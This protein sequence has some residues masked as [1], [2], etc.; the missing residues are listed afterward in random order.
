MKSTNT[1]DVVPRTAWM[2]G[3]QPPAYKFSPRARRLLISKYF[4]EQLQ[5]YIYYW[6][7]LP[8]VSTARI[9]WNRAKHDAHASIRAYYR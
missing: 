2:G 6:Q 9:F 8:P 1:P 3:S 5:D 4:R 7:S